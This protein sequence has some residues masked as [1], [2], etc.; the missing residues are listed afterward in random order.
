[1]W[2]FYVRDLEQSVKFYTK[3]V[4]L[5]LVGTLFNGRAAL[6]KSLKIGN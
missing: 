5:G 2:Y 6:L 4:D 1:M 3:A